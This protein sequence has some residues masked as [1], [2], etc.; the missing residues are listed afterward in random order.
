MHTILLNMN[1]INMVFNVHVFLVVRLVRCGRDIADNV[2]MSA[3]QVQNIDWLLALVIR[4]G[5]RL[6]MSLR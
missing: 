2:W 1:H 4:S 3:L 6:R 5:L